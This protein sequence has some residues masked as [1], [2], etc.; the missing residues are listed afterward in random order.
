MGAN[1]VVETLARTGGF[2]VKVARHR[3][4]ETTQH[5]L[6]VTKSLDSIKPGGEGHASTIRVRLLHAA[7]RRR[8][9]KLAKERPDY[10]DIDKFGI[11]INEL[12][13]IATIVTFSG[14]L[15]WVSFPRQGITMRPQEILD[16]LALWR[17]VAHYIG[18]PPEIFA[19]PSKTKAVME[20]LMLYEISPSETSK[21]LANNVINSLAGR[22]PAYASREFLSASARWLNGRELSDALALPNPSF[23]YTLLMLGQCLFF[24]ILIRINRAI[25]SWDARQIKR[26][27]HI[28][29]AVIVDKKMHGLGEETSFDFKY[30]PEFGTMTQ[31]EE[32]AVGEEKFGVE[33]RNLRTLLL[34]GFGFT[35][36]VV[37]SWR[38]VSWSVGGA[39]RLFNA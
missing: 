3:M 25:P 32:Y 12:D 33:R 30:I 6:Q 9:L 36:A 29:W 38:I 4:Y 20:S 5:I 13:S 23:Y 21:L 7:V 17:L 35:V 8:I 19:S 27:R 16:Y 18:T 14:T 2:G 37:V 31:L 22:P 24:N 10:Y 26:V 15:I 39:L 34:T 1:R 28:F 11:P